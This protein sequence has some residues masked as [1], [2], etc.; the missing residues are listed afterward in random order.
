MEY[1]NEIPERSIEYTQ[2][3]S[4]L[5]NKEKADKKV[6]GWKKSDTNSNNGSFGYNNNNNNSKKQTQSSKNKLDN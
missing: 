2:K 5:K 1:L 6:K 4:E 3:S